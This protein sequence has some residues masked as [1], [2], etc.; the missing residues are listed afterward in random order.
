MNINHFKQ[1]TQR[2]IIA[3]QQNTI[4]DIHKINLDCQ[5]NDKP[6]T[7]DSI[8]EDYKVKKVSSKNFFRSLDP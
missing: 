7:M 2:K 3:F 5:E 8:L 1:V 4:N 6:C